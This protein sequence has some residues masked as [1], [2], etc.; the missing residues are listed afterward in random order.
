MFN[1]ALRRNNCFRLHNASG[2]V[3]CLYKTHL[4][5]IYIN[6]SWQGEL[7]ILNT[8]WW[9]GQT[10]QCQ[11]L[12]D[13]HSFSIYAPRSTPEDMLAYKYPPEP[14]TF[15]QSKV[16]DIQVLTVAKIICSCY[17]LHVLRAKPAVG[18]VDESVGVDLST[19]LLQERQH[20]NYN[21]RNQRKT[22]TWD[23]ERM[24]KRRGNLEHR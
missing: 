1:G 23:E 17:S 3:S 13:Q 8:T 21:H 2:L 18:I 14:L 16:N 4:K 9:R 19:G 5:Q 24:E 12:K 20:R 10:P 6:I 11:T 7:H 15:T 22:D